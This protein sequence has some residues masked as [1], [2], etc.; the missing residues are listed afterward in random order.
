MHSKIGN[1]YQI[2]SPAGSNIQCSKIFEYIQLNNNIIYAQ[3]KDEEVPYF[4]ALRG[5][6]FLQASKI[7]IRMA[8]MMIWSHDVGGVVKMSDTAKP[9]LVRAQT[10]RPIR[11]KTPI[12]KFASL[13]IP[14]SYS[15]SETV[16]S[17]IGL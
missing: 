16:S 11:E 13:G 2:N 1:S 14:S 8:T 12:R 5:E 10:E 15:S 17:G 3:L 6:E 4:H 7:I 9:K